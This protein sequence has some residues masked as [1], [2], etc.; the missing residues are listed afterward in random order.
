MAIEDLGY[1]NEAR[2]TGHAPS[3]VRSMLK[4]LRAKLEQ[5]QAA[6]RVYTLRGGRSSAGRDLLPIV[7]EALA[8]WNKLDDLIS[9]EKRQRQRI[10]ARMT[11]YVSIFSEVNALVLRINPKER[12]KRTSVEK[13][14]TAA[15]GRETRRLRG[16]LGKR[17]KQKL[18]ANTE[19][20]TVTV[21]APSPRGRR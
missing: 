3:R 9:Q 18:K 6:N 2:P 17:Q 5:K 7:D 12:R 20:L 11:P 16:T 19:G 4:L 15:K 13:I 10:A 14:L 1:T 21:T 8:E